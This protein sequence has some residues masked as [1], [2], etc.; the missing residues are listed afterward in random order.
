V[1]HRL[2]HPEAYV[3]EVLDLAL[4]YGE[5][6]AEVVAAST[7]PGI[8]LDWALA[9][10]GTP[11]IWGGETPGVGFDCSG[12]VQAAYAA[13]GVSLPR[14]AQTQYDETQKLGPG[15]PLEPGDLVFFGHGPSD[16]THVGIYAGVEGFPNT[17]ASAWGTEEYVGATTLA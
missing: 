2:L 1:R 15:D 8:A 16:V 12:L 6:D 14:T 13:A 11:Y 5:T 3:T 7:A 4:S 17:L 10:V 9:Q